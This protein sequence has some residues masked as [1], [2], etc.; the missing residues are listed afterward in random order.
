MVVLWQQVRE[1]SSDQVSGLRQPHPACCLPSSP[2]AWLGWLR[3][4]GAPGDS[5]AWAAEDPMPITVDSCHLSLKRA[6]CRWLSG[7][8]G[9]VLWGSSITVAFLPFSPGSLKAEH[10]GQVQ[11]HAPYG[12]AR[13]RENHAPYGG[14]GHRENHAPY[15]SAGYRENHAPMAA[16]GTGRTMPSMAV[17]GTGRT[18]SP[19]AALGTGRTMPSIAVLGMGEPCPLWQRWAQRE[20]YPLWQHWAQGELCLNGEQELP[21]GC[22]GGGAPEAAEDEAWNFTGEL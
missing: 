2:L 22:P 5:E 3:C 15:G 10:K 6:W 14:T 21:V 20:L 4:P 1:S 18:M 12:S 17:L 8:A 13:H 19:M 7:A 11:N 9:A 16:L